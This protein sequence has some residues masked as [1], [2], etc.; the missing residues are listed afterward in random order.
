MCLG[1]YYGCWN[2]A[3]DT[4]TENFNIDVIN[5]RKYGKSPEVHQSY[6]HE[7][8]DLLFPELLGL[9]HLVLL[10][11]SEITGCF[12]NCQPMGCSHHS[13][14]G[15][16]EWLWHQLAA[17]HRSAQVCPWANM[18]HT[19]HG[20][21]R[22]GSSDAPVWVA[23]R[24]G[25]FF[26]SLKLLFDGILGFPTPFSRGMAAF[27]KKNWFFVK[28]TPKLSAKIFCFFKEIFWLSA[29][30][31]CWN[32]FFFRDKNPLVPVFHPRIA[33]LGAVTISSYNR[34]CHKR[35]HKYICFL[36]FG[37]MEPICRMRTQG[38]GQ[39]KG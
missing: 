31:L 6:F 2:L 36:F 8:V 16:W 27:S 32:I 35:E 30:T 15:K 18:T 37:G 10:W 19:Q 7:L 28:K 25:D 33:S 4:E 26:F 38:W 24:V 17:K 20:R 39:V 34:C 5:W 9:R 11:A 29:E 3:L 23:A 22:K 1:C 12:K 21:T 13:S 14:I